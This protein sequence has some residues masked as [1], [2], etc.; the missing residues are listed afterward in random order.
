M[1]VEFYKQEIEGYKR[2]IVLMNKIHKESQEDV[3][4]YLKEYCSDLSEK[5]LKLRERAIVRSD[6]KHLE[7]VAKIEG[8]IAKLSK[9]INQ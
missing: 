3:K 5:E 1:N 2:Q 7:R 8:K 9:M 6:K 4:E